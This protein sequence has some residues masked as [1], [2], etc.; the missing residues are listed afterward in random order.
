MKPSKGDQHAVVDLVD[1][2]LHKGAVV[3]AD[4]L[5]TVADIPLVGLKLRAALAG[6]ATM[7]EYGMFEEWDEVQR[8]LNREEK[9]RHP[10]KSNRLTTPPNDEAE[11]EPDER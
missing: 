10:L 1:M 5:I 4:V 11:A 7:R 2:L 9:A 8:E 3:E 6:M